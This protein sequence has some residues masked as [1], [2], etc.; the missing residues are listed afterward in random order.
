M[1]MVQSF[2][3]KIYNRR[4]ETRV[5]HHDRGVSHGHAI[6]GWPRT[7]DGAMCAAAIVRVDER[8]LLGI[9]LVLTGV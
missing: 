2:Y 7:G 5:R 1:G 3:A 9:C 4:P 6:H 8:H